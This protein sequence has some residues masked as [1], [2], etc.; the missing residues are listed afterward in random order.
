MGKIVANPTDAG[1][2]VILTTTEEGVTG[3]YFDREG[4]W[5]EFGGGQ[6]ISLQPIIHVTLVNDGGE[7]PLTITR[8]SLNNLIMN[9]HIYNE[10][11][12][13]EEIPTD[14]EYSWDAL[15]HIDRLPF[16]TTD[17]ARYNAHWVSRTD[18]SGSGYV[19]KAYELRTSENCTFD[20]ETGDII[21][22]D[23]TKEASAVMVV[24]YT[25]E[26]DEG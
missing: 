10:F 13:N 19:K 21:V 5:H 23:I 15:C 1:Q 18:Y 25:I 2:A 17:D 3:G 8:M 4:V 12:Y 22:T 14:G 9:G 26:Q 16:D 24:T 7:N 20:G 11:P 6:G